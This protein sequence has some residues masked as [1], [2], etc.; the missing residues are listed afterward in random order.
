MCMM[1]DNSSHDQRYPLS[2]VVDFGEMAGTTADVEFRTALI[3]E[4]E[5]LLDYC[6]GGTRR[7]VRGAGRE[8]GRRE[9]GREA[10]GRE[11]GG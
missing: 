2:T 5:K 9:G 10:G 11:G 3:S 4:V 1:W 7:S 6:N 8:G